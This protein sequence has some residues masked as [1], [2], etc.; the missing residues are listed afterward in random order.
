M[1][2]NPP[3]SK[4]PP[5]QRALQQYLQDLDEKAAGKDFFFNCYDQIRQNPSGIDSSDAAQINRILQ[6]KVAKDMKS[7]S[8][9][10]RVMQR[11]AKLQ[12]QYDGF[13]NSLS[14]LA[15]RFVLEIVLN[16][17]AAVFSRI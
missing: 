7:S 15:L 11:L 10:G 1:V 3:H 9:T 8:S 5:L 16:I 14:K 13:V 12:Q 4:V 6:G 2:N 17:F